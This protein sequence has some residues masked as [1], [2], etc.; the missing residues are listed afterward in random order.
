MSEEAALRAKFEEESS[1]KVSC[2]VH[3][4]LQFCGRVADKVIL[5]HPPKTLEISLL[6]EQADADGELIAA[7][8]EE[9]KRLADDIERATSADTF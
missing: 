7:L 4:L 3:G 1:S 9:Q 5:A 2:T 8:E 6:Q